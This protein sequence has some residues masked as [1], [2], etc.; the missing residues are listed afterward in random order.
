MHEHS[1]ARFTDGSMRWRNMAW[2]TM[3]GLQG[4]ASKLPASRVWRL[5]EML[6]P[7][8]VFRIVCARDR[9]RRPRFLG[10]SDSR[11]RVGLESTSSALAL[12]VLAAKTKNLSSRI[13]LFNFQYT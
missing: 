10:I 3:P 12:F 13:L 8:S 5:R 11:L 2:V 6:I 4:F 9:K 1:C 7:A